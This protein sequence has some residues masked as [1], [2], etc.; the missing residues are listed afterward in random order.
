M[1]TIEE[2][3]K[4]YDEALGKARKYII[5]AYGCSRVK[6]IDIFPEL[7][8]SEDERIR[9][10]IKKIIPDWWRRLGDVTPGFSTE[11]EMLAWLEKQKEGNLVEKKYIQEAFNKGMQAGM[12]QKPAE[13]SEEDDFQRREA[14]EAVMETD[15]SD[16]RKADVITWLK[17][18]HP[19]N[20]WKPTSEQM[21]LLNWLTLG[22]GDGPV[23]DKARKVMESLYNGLKKL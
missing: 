7:A 5:D 21:Y 12:M 2:K 11:E 18:I 10:D 13:W 3:A 19:E 4:A 14:I 17:S 1:K 15:Y 20:R 23:A 8:E 9:K 16:A 22:L 6:I